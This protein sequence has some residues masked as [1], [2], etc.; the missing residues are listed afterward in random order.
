MHNKPPHRRTGDLEVNFV[1]AKAEGYSITSWSWSCIWVGLLIFGFETGSET[2][3][4]QFL[5]INQPLSALPAINFTYSCKVFETVFPRIAALIPFIK[6]WR[7]SHPT[8]TIFRPRSPV[9]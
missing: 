7:E 1:I 4:R 8:A 9:D 6:K 5:K 2:F 3:K